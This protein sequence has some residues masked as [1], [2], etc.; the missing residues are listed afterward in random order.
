[1]K[2]KSEKLRFF[3]Q[4]NKKLKADKIVLDYSFYETILKEMEELKSKIEKI[5]KQNS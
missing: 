5:K 2:K 1:M 3:Y 4:Q